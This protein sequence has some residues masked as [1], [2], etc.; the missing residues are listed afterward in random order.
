MEGVKIIA[1]KVKKCLVFDFENYNG[2]G[3]LPEPIIAKVEYSTMQFRGQTANFL[4]ILSKPDYTK[5]TALM[6]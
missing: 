6:A 3:E 4:R 2:R 5:Q 1:S